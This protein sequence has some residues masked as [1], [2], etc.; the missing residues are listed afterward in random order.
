MLPRNKGE[1]PEK[2]LQTRYWRGG[3]VC[4]PVSG[5]PVLL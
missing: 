4:S 3:T 2:G 5:N 1:K